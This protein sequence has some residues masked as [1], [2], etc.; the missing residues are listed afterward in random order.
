[1]MLTQP[2]ILMCL[3]ATALWFSATCVRSQTFPPRPAPGEFVLDEAVLLHAGD[4]QRIEGACA[5]L[6]KEEQIPIVVVTI[7]SLA[8]YHAKNIE[9]YARALFD[10]WGI[11]SQ[12][13]NYGVLLLVSRGDRKARI[14][15]GAAWAHARDETVEMIMKDIMI[16][17]FKKGDYSS[18][19][20]RGVQALDTMARGQS[21]RKPLAWVPLLLREGLVVLGVC[22]AVSRRDDTRELYVTNRLG[23][24]SLR[25]VFRPA[26]SPLR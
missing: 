1:M 26:I 13:R 11:G 19:I 8:K 23:N 5:K 24:L 25:P 3:L 10:N 9:V 22:T 16:P 18:G 2:N 12:T 20:L 15:L 14:E 7:P 21:V 17:N 6:M 4:Q